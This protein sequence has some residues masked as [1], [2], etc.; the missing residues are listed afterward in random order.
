M[1]EEEKCVA[2]ARDVL[3]DWFNGYL[4]G[5]VLQELGRLHGLLIETTM[6]EPCG[7]NCRCN[8]YGANFPTVCYRYA[9]IVK[10]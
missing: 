5:G 9:D 4:R 3:R 7:D 10:P 1:T 8:E 6:T 2:F